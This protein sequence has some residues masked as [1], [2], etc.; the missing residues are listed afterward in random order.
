MGKSTWEEELDEMGT[1]T[2]KGLLEWLGEDEGLLTHKAWNLR[3]G[4]E[5]NDSMRKEMR[6]I[7]EKLEED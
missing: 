7:I 5:F 3:H 2:K 4:F 6:R 1:P